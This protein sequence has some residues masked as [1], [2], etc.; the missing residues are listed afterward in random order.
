[1]SEATTETTQEAQEARLVRELVGG[2]SHAA[3]LKLAADLDRRSIPPRKRASEGVFY[4]QSSTG[5]FMLKRCETRNFPTDAP[6]DQ[7]G[8]LTLQDFWVTDLHQRDRENWHLLWDPIGE[9]LTVDW[10]P[11]DRGGQ[12]DEP[13]PLSVLADPDHCFVRLLESLKKGE[14]TILFSRVVGGVSEDIS[15]PLAA[16]PTQA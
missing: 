11:V 15:V 2:L 8:T 10:L 4:L 12:P 3:D 1:M 5:F 9:G 6:K 7:E 14:G 16:S 13:M